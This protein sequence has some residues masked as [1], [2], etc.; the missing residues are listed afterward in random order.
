MGTSPLNAGVSLTNKPASEDTDEE[1]WRPLSGGTVNNVRRKGDVVRRPWNPQ[2]EAILQVFRRLGDRRVQ[3]IPQILGRTRDFVELRYIEGAPVLRPWPAEVKTDAWLKQLGNWLAV[4]HQAIEGF[5]LRNGARF[6]WGPDTPAAG[7]IVCHGDLGPWNFL[8]VAGNLTGVIDW[9]LA[10]F[11]PALDNLAHLATEMVPLREPRK[12]NMGKD[13]SRSQRMH[14][15]EV[16]LDAF[17]NVNPS[18]L[19][20]H[21]LDW[22]QR[23]IKETESYAQR[24]VAPFDDFVKRGFLEEYAAD[25][26]Y[27]QEV[28]IDH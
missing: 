28:W 23:L 27:I 13:I 26:H 25:C 17:G 20:Q 9:D 11:G 12:D 10:Y 5:E 16:L 19:L 14:R 4:Y 18:E 7:M 15:L 1:G 3:G 2:S 8:H 6:I 24:G 21:T 22:Y